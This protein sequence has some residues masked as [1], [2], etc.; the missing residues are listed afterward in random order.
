MGDNV[1]A[2]LKHDCKNNFFEGVHMARE[3]CVADVI[4]DR[5]R[6]EVDKCENLQGFFF[7]HA[8][9]GGTGSGVGFKLLEALRDQF[10]K[11]LIFQPVIY[12]SARLSSCIVEPYNSI[13]SLHNTKD[14]VDLTLMLDNEKAYKIVKN[15]LGIKEPSYLHVNRLIAKFVSACTSSLRYDSDLNATLAELVTNLTPIPTFRY[16]L[17]S[18]APLKPYNSRRHEH[19]KVSELVTDLFDEKYTLCDCGQ[20]PNVLRNNRYLSCA[21]LLRGKNNCDPADPE[22]AGGGLTIPAHEAMS[23]LRNMVKPMG[24]HRA[25]LNFIPPLADRGGFKVG[26]VGTPPVLPNEDFMADREQHMMAATQR[27]GALLS[28]TT[29]VRMLFVKQYDKFLKLFFHKAYIWQFIEASG[30]TDSFFEARE[31]IRFMIDSYEQLLQ[32][33]VQAEN[34]KNPDNPVMLTNATHPTV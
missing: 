9:G 18:M 12:P 26:I 8:M 7:F 23:A 30:E 3:Y 24:S 4:M 13:L 20:S 14:L 6:I 31:S 25:A 10:D 22:Y 33:C 16:P 29:A 1:L 32:Q 11:K 2:C 5:V 34:E 19:F 21:V 27:Q 17:I 15:D 28:N